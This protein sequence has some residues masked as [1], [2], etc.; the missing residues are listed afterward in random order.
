MDEMKYL[1][2]TEVFG[3]MEADLVESYLEANGVDVEL[4]QDSIERTSYVTMMGRVQVFVPIDKAEEAR[5]LL[6][7]YR[8]ELIEEPD[9]E[10]EE[11]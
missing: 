8:E 9:E 10:D 5:E 1:K 7:A 11:A 4:V 3:R 6:K 2:I